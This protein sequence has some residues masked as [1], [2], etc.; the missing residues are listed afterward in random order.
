MVRGLNDSVSKVLDALEQRAVSD[1][2]QAAEMQRRRDEFGGEERLRQERGRLEASRPGARGLA[3]CGERA[4]E[5][6]AYA[7]NLRD[8]LPH[9]ESVERERIGAW[10]R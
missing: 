10:C 5:L 9:L 3:Q 8:R 7:A 1:M 6:P 2:Q 4:R